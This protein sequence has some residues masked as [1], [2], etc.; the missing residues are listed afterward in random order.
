LHSV[1]HMGLRID[2]TMEGEFVVMTLS[3]HVALLELAELRLLMEAESARR[4]I[5][6]LRDVIQMDRDAVALLASFEVAGV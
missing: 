5:V 3:G 2:R 1:R 6:D 4:L